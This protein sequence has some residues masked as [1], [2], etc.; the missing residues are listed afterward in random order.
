M[1]HLVGLIGLAIALFVST[2]IDDVFVLLGFF[3]D[4]KFKMRQIV[5][6]QYLG[7][8]GLYGASVVASLIALVIAPAFIGLL[9][10]API[11][12]GLKKAWDLRKGADASEAASE[13]HEKASAGHGNVVAVAAVTLANGGDNISIYTPLFAARSAYD[14]AVIGVV[15]AL[16]TLVWL[17]AARWLTHHRTLG[18]PIRH[19][20]HRVVPFVLIALGI[21]ILDEAGTFELLR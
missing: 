2:N 11:A 18:A 10:L 1:E 5:V 3:A 15:F 9:G 8:I 7:I 20:R 16:M 12:I 14:V 19:Y 6:G 13:D 17:W 4:P 21:L